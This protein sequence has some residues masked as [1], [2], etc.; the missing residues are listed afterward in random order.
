MSINSTITNRKYKEIE[1]SDFI[2]RKK[3][4]GTLF[5]NV[6]M[7]SNITISSVLDVP[8]NYGLDYSKIEIDIKCL[9]S[10]TK[11]NRS[12]RSRI[13]NRHRAFLRGYSLTLSQQISDFVTVNNTQQSQLFATIPV[14]LLND[15]TNTTDKFYGDSAIQPLLRIT[16]TSP[17]D[18]IK[19]PPISLSANTISSILP[20]AIGLTILTS[21][22]IQD[23]IDEMITILCEKVLEQFVDYYNMIDNT[24][25]LRKDIIR[26]L[27]YAFY[28][29]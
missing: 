19:Y 27:E 21:P 25:A 9:Q 28:G 22:S 6:A 10:S 17:Q 14:L 1:Y 2:L 18:V 4:D 20:E 16:Y 26:Y 7:S 12:N 3:I 5:S 13:A 23:V 11:T 8:S 15:L 29:N 24:T